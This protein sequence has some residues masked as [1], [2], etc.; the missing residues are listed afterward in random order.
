MNNEIAAL[1]NAVNQFGERF[2]SLV[3]GISVGSEDLYRNSPQGIAAGSY[4]GAEPAKIAEYI[5]RTRQSL[6]DTC[7]ARAP[8]GHVDTWTAW[9]NNSNQAVIN[10]CDWIGMDAYPYF[11]E[12]HA[13]AIAA[14]AQLFN[15]ALG[16]TQ[17]AVAGKP[18]WI[19]ETGWPV[20]GKTVG[21]AVPSLQNAKAF[22][23]DVGCPMFGRVNVWW[24]TFQDANPVTPNPSFGIVGSQLSNQP[25]F[26][27]SCSS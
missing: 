3:A 8:I 5:T 7:L 18:V 24:Y 4:V 9:V 20:S 10:G 23:N 6:A 26:D 21:A 22:W 12:T 27:L 13:N 15:D 19:T 1:R 2:C 17:A 14:G 16:K 11:E 25:L